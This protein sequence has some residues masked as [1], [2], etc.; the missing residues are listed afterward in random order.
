MN[1]DDKILNCGTCGHSAIIHHMALSSACKGSK[2]DGTHCQCKG[3]NPNQNSKGQELTFGEK[4]T[5]DKRP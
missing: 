2:K 5:F 3:F 1:H 4:Y